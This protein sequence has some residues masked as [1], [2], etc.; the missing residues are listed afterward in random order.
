MR[1]H[2]SFVLFFCF[3][4]TLFAQKQQKTAAQY[5]EQY[6]DLAIEE[7]L[8]HKIPA[9][10]TLAQA[11]HES[12]NG[13]SQ[14]ARNANNHFGVKCSSKWTGK[15]YYRNGN[16]KNNCFRKYPSV[17]DAYKD[18]SRFLTSNKNYARLFTYDPTN[19]RAWAYGLQKSGYAASKSYAK[20]LI[21]TIEKHKLQQYDLY[22]STY[23]QKDSLGQLNFAL[24]NDSF[25][26]DSSKVIAMQKV[27]AARKKEL[28][29]IKYHT[30]KKGQTLSGIA[31][32]Y[33]TSVSKLKKLNG[34]KSDKIK[35]GT[36]LRV[37]WKSN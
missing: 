27:E 20:L 10:I 6:K 8:I 28:N 13:N 21:N 30:V 23:F 18:R 19:Y 34:L 1:F 7:M 12:A 14:L 24:R 4:T 25:R 22:D 11:L 16:K 32:K 15:K 33:H 26:V 9:S 17:A 2:F 35:P 29:A 3:A 36:R 5:V 37:K 31:Q